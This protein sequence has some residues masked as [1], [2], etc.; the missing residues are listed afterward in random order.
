[1]TTPNLKTLKKGKKS[2][3]DGRKNNRGGKRDGSGRKRSEEK[4]IVQGVRQLIDQHAG[5]EVLVEIKDKN[6]K[7]IKKIPKPRSLILLEKLFDVGQAQGNIAA[8]KEW[9][10]R[11]VGKAP[12]P[13][14]GDG[15]NDA[16]IR[17]G[18]DIDSILDKAYGDD[19]DK[20]D[21]DDDDDD[22]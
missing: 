4:L 3:P 10:D 11:A 6:G 21:D 2:K 20:D 5:E 9:F 8:I 16:P 18:I 17:I 12:Q 13:I 22:N 1:M 7:V 15:D 14:R 19:A